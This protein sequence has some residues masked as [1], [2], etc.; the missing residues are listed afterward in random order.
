MHSHL[1]YELLFS[2]TSHI[3]EV[4]FDS[5]I[6]FNLFS[7]N[8]IKKYSL[9]WFIELSLASI[10][11]WAVFF[12]LVRI[13]FNLITLWISLLC[14]NNI[15]STYTL[16]IWRSLSRFVLLGGH[17]AIINK[18]MWS[19]YVHRVSAQLACTIEH[20]S[21]MHNRLNIKASKEWQFTVIT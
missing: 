1:H 14:F 3:Y 10:P 16:F 7:F 2:R 6:L 8:I 13:I 20:F 9:F 11:S 4:L 19:K 17:H 21:Q 18:V 15:L 5:T 12:R